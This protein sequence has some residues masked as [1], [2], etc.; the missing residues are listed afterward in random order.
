MFR[1]IERRT[2]FAD[3]RD[4]KDILARFERI[5]PECGVACYAWAL[6]PNHLHLLVRTGAQP[7]A[8]AMARIGTGY[9]QRFNRRHARVG[10][11]FQNRYKSI[12]VLDDVQL[13]VLIRYIH[14]NPVRAGLVAGLAALERFPWTGHA[15]LMGRRRSAFQDV[16][17]V[18]E[19]FGSQP[20]SGRAKLRDWMRDAAVAPDARP[21]APLVPRAIADLVAWV[22]PELGVRPSVVTSGSRR[23]EASHARAVIAHLACDVLGFGQGE[24]ALAIGVTATA[25]GRARR[26]GALLVM[27]RGGR[28]AAWKRAQTE[29]A[30]VPT[31]GSRGVPEVRRK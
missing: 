28:L 15:A 4:R 19:L 11:L 22:G 12:P 18:L 2:I 8:R 27:R 5:L 14:L 21:D 10:H 31:R 3:D 29:R 1:G 9:A 7:L 26:Q 24:V 23:R 17:A 13:L 16:A 20:A 25:V 6:M 30:A